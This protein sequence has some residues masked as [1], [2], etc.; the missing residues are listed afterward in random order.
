MTYYYGGLLSSICNAVGSLNYIS[1]RDANLVQERHRSRE[2]SNPLFEA[3]I[4]QSDL[5]KKKSN[6]KPE[7]KF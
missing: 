6:N 2:A 4:G 5:P 1:S 3:N 7:S